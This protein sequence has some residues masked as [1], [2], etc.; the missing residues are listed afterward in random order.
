MLP[1]FLKREHKRD[2]IIARRMLFHHLMMELKIYLKIQENNY[3]TKGRALS[4][5]A[6]SINL[7][8][9]DYIYSSFVYPM[10]FPITHGT[11][12]AFALLKINSSFE[13]SSPRPIKSEIWHMDEKFMI[14][15]VNSFMFKL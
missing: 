6:D 12:K 9:H 13:Y 10:L 7:H 11:S 3:F 14:P 15:L 1:N 4:Q 5:M 8:K 2:E